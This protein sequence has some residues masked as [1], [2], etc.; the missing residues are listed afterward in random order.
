MSKFKE[1]VNFFN[2]LYFVLIQLRIWIERSLICV[3]FVDKEKQSQYNWVCDNI[4]HVSLFKRAKRHSYKQI[5]QMVCKYSW[6]WVFTST[7]CKNNKNDQLNKTRLIF[8]STLKS[9]K[10]AYLILNNNT[11]YLQS[12]H[13]FIRVVKPMKCFRGVKKVLIFYWKFMFRGLLKSCKSLFTKL[14]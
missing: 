7:Y 9:N 10:Y 2:E 1:K 11:W 3:V 8:Y 13:H 6:K 4:V 5:Q 14:M 12:T